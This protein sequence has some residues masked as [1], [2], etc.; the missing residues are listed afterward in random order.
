SSD[1]HSRGNFGPLDFESTLDFWPGE[2]QENFTYIIDNPGR[3]AAQDIVD[4]LRSGN[5]F[6]VQGQL[7]DDMDFKV[8]SMSAC[9]TMGETLQVSPGEMV[10][11]SLEVRDPDGE[12]RSPYKFDNPSLLQIGRSVP[13]N[14]PEV[15]QVTF[16]SGVVGE[17]FTPADPEYFEPLA[18]ETTQIAATYN[19]DELK[20]GEDRVIRLGYKTSITQDSYIRVTGSNIPAGTPN[21]RDANGNPLPDNL[22]D[23]IPCLDAACPPHVFGILTADLEA[24]AD[25][26]FH[27]NPVFIEVVGEQRN[28]K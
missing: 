28:K 11:V 2:Y 14:E 19:D 8:C 4:G 22:S 16:I 15:A 26:S 17:Q 12:N 13:L 25:L 21:E 3:D 18:P 9:A 5:T 23:N 7:I 27:S 6:T 20:R 1:W 10:K 24:W